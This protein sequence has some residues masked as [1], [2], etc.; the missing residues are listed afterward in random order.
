MCQRSN[1]IKVLVAY[2]RKRKSREN[3]RAFIYNSKIID[4]FYENLG[5]NAN[6]SVILYHNLIS[7]CINLQD[8]T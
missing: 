7:Q 5:I 2:Q 8:Q 1:Q 3:P 4:N 6:T